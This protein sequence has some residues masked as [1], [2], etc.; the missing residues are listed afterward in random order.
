[1][2][3]TSFMSG[4]CQ[5]PC[6]DVAPKFRRGLDW[7]E[8]AGTV[9]WE[10]LTYACASGRLGR[11]QKKSH[12]GRHGDR[13]QMS[14]HVIGLPR[15]KASWG[16]RKTRRPGRQKGLWRERVRR[17]WCTSSSV[18][19]HGVIQGPGRLRG[20]HWMCDWGLSWVTLERALS[21][22][23]IKLQ[24]FKRQEAESVGQWEALRRREEMM[25]RAV[26]KAGKVPWKENWKKRPLSGSCRWPR[27]RHR[28]QSC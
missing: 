9:I 23:G 8:G 15:I 7:R 11:S 22:A 27:G 21:G 19:G 18:T 12:V 1:M 14:P 28:S 4:S 6:G 10:S 16:Q 17:P 3:T 26:L 25:S 24:R 13:G 5:R 2:E 20:N